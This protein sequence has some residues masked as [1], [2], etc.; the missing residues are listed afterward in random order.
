MKIA[1]ASNNQSLISAH[2]GRTRG[3]VIA[4]IQNN[5]VINKEYRDNTFTEHSHH[6]GDHHHNHSD[7]DHNHSHENILNALRDCQAVISNGMGRRIYDDLQSVNIKP[8]I[9]T[10]RN[11][12]SAI[13]L[14]IN[15]K[16][17][18]NPNLGC[19]H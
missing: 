18:D 9:T 13:E 1:V 2:F 15:N 12:D 5:K 8:Y 4:E 17:D 14:F 3:F 16:L 19:R 6:S 7:G 10:E 11:V